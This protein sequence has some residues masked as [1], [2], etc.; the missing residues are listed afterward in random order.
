MIVSIACSVE[1]GVSA[2]VPVRK[3]RSILAVAGL[4]EGTGWDTRARK[5]G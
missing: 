5:T 3:Y 2:K 4:L 1:V